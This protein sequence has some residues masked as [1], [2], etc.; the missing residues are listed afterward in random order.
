MII[1]ITDRHLYA[2]E[3]AYL[4]GIKAQLN[5][6]VDYLILR[7]KALSLEAYDALVGLII[8]A[9]ANALDKL[10][11]HTHEAVALKYKIPRLHLPEHLI[12]KA[13]DSKLS[14]SYSLH[15]EHADLDAVVNECWFFLV[16]PVYPSTCKP[17]LEPM[18]WGL[19]NDLKDNYGDK[20]VLL[21]GLN[22]ERIKTLKAKGYKH[23]ALRSKITR[24]GPF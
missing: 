22:Q 10:I 18:D 4:M 5:G 12:Q 6:S 24:D 7:D 17:G 16:S 14:L 20:L 3:A 19:I 23:F 11:I 1:G 13:Y 8:S 2:S 15:P 21:G 9:N